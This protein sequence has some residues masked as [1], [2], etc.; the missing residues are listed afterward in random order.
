MAERMT[1]VVW[2]A[3]LAAVAGNAAAQALND[4]M[5]PPMIS[6]TGAEPETAAGPSLQSILISPNRKL[7]VIDGQTVPLGGRI[8]DATL[9]EISGASVML[10]RNGELER[11][12]M[13]PPGIDKKPAPASG[14]PD[15]D[16]RE[17]R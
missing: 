11:L 1:V 9:I 8:G 6:S 17:K 15:K 3:I 7:A 16:K 12:R 2:A 13:Y 10:K 14:G 4:P 5:R